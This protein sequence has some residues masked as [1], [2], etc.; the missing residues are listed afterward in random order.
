MRRS[1]LTQNRK[2]YPPVRHLESRRG[3]V[4]EFRLSTH[5]GCAY[6]KHSARIGST[7]AARRAGIPITNPA[8]IIHRLS[9]S[10]IQCHPRAPLPAPAG[11]QSPV[12][13]APPHT[14]LLQTI[15]SPP[16]APQSLRTSSP[17]PQTSLRAQRLPDLLFLRPH[18]RHKH[19]FVI[20]RHNPLHRSCK[21]HRR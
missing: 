3:L 12:S 1:A 13:A 14:P 16:V 15:Q 21:R 4:V 19:T 2:H 8:A 20:P 9:R 18:L 6:S 5:K 7:H 10:T 11:S 17:R